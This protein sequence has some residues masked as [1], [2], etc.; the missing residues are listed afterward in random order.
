MGSVTGRIIARA[1]EGVDEPKT[2]VEGASLVFSPLGKEL[3]SDVLLL[4]H[5]PSTYLRSVVGRPTPQP[6]L[7]PALLARLL[8]A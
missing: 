3:G 7:E 6:N 5:V 4:E 8:P 2:V 1:V